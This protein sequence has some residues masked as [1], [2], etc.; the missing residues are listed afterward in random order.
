[1][2]QSRQSTAWNRTGRVARETRPCFALQRSRATV[3]HAAFLLV[4]IAFASPAAALTAFG[5]ATVSLPSSAPPGTIVARQYYSPQEFCGKDTCTITD[6]ALFDKGSKWSP[7]NGPDVSTNVSGLSTRMLVDGT[8]VTSSLKT[9]VRH[10]VEVQLFRDSRAPQSGSLS[11]GVINSY[12]Q[13][14]YKSGLFGDVAVV[15][16]AADVSFINGTCSVPDQT[17]TLPPVQQNAFKGVGSTAGTVDFQ[18]RLNN[19]P[20]GYNRIGYQLSPLDGAVAGSPGTLQLRPESTAAGVGIQ[21]ADGM[22]GNPLLLRQSITVT[23]YN[24]NTGGSPSIPLRAS[25]IQTDATIKG[26]SVRAAAQVL[27]DYQ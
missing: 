20:A 7:V 23:G 17:V 26:G 1:M 19:C 8:P 4:S 9:T 15:H 10:A 25:Y 2:L 3:L 22:T 16:L 18:L 27:L 11:P 14:T 6:A 24:K 5:N 13:I 12:Y 21:I